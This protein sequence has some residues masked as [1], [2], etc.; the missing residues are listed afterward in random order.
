M[1]EDLAELER[2]TSDWLL[3]LNSHKCTIL[4]LGNNNPKLQY[5]INGETLKAVEE[6]V[7]LG[8]TIALDLKW[9]TQVLKVV[10][11]ANSLLY[12]I[13]RSF[14]SMSLETFKVIYKSYVRPVLEHA[15]MA[16]SPY[17][18]KD[19]DLLERV[20]RRATKIPTSL[21]LLPYEERLRALQLPKL[22]DRRARGDLIECY[23]ILH[24]HYS[25]DLS[26]MF[27]Y[28]TNF[29]LRGHPYK[30]DTERCNRLVR[31]HFLSNRV[32]DMWN[33]LPASVVEAPG[34]NAFKNGLDQIWDS[35]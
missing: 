12:L 9:E 15:V 5:F 6:Q 1:S 7:D 26:H 28:N 13:R 33:R 29:H 11:R 2:W 14:Y 20:Q 16:W 8:V 24:G 32:V 21:R 34:L 10:K 18:Q 22:V 19:I 35:L 3:K 30:L 27:T 25:C 23:K 31:K 4:H 17:F